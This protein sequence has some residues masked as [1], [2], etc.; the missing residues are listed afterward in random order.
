MT[1]SSREVLSMPIATS[2]P[3]SKPEATPFPDDKLIEAMEQV[4]NNIYT[5]AKSWSAWKDRTMKREDFIPFNR[6]DELFHEFVISFKEAYLAELDGGKLPD[7]EKLLMD[8]FDKEELDPLFNK[9]INK[10]FYENRFYPM[11]AAKTDLSSLILF[12]ADYQ[13]KVALETVLVQEKAVKRKIK[14]TA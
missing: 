13:A 11:T 12:V 3:S 5:C 14:M 4:F 7:I 1:L 6:E 9:D 2:I 8:T 10:K